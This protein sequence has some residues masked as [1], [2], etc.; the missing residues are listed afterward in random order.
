MIIGDAFRDGDQQVI[1]L[2][3]ILIV[4][5]AAVACAVDGGKIRVVF[6]VNSVT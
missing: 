6:T 4:G 3:Q 1:G 5:G 2:E